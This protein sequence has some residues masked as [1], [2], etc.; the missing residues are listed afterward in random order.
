M[1]DLRNELRI[2]RSRG[3][4]GKEYEDAI[5]HGPTHDPPWKTTTPSGG[6]HHERR[7]DNQFIA[8][9]R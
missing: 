6:R 5:D 4:N 9:P 1:S 2:T 3:V 7:I 8:A